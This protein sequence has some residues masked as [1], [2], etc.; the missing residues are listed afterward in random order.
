MTPQD[1]YTAFA[2]PAS[3]RLGKRVFKKLFLENGDLTAADKRALSDSVGTITW[4]YTLKPSTLPVQ[5]YRDGEQES[6]D[7]AHPTGSSI[8][9]SKPWGAALV[10][11]W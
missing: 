10:S 3:C 9:S 4:Q 5:P 6:H 7:A 11:G 1:L 8:S 2:F